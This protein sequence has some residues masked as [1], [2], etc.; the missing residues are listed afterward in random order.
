MRTLLVF[1]MLVNF[2]SFEMS[3]QNPSPRFM[4]EPA[5]HDRGFGFGSDLVQARA[6][7]FIFEGKCKEYYKW[8]YKRYQQ[9]RQEY[10]SFCKKAKSI[11]D[12]DARDS[13]YSLYKQQSQ[14]KKS[15]QNPYPRHNYVVMITPSLNPTC[16]FAVENDQLVY[17][18]ITNLDPKKP[19]AKCN[20]LTSDTEV[21]PEL[22]KTMRSLMDNIV[23]SAIV[24][25]RRSKRM[26]GSTYSIITGPFPTHMVKSYGGGQNAEAAVCSL[27][28]RLCKAAKNK[29]ATA[30]NAE[31]S[32][33]QRLSSIYQK[34]RSEKQD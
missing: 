30:I 32:E 14:E 4:A 24:T 17:L 3:A 2:F 26:D 25:D 6:D 33:I 27:L 11:K 16:G 22:C 18:E 7:A 15:V 23:N 13:L 1:L 29:D 9:N 20:V 28:E 34:L 5:V 31:L 10:K 12:E 8:E 21:S 19:D